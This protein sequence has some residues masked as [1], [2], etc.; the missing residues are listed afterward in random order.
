ME[1]FGQRLKARAREL[2]LSD[3]E[4]A[5]RAGL[6][7]RRYGHY[8]TDHREP[9]LKTVVLISEVLATTPNYLLGVEDGKTPSGKTGEREQLRAQVVATCDVLD[10]KHLQ[11]AVK[12]VAVLVE[13]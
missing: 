12:L 4:V 9:D 5:R 6:G 1:G 11:M 2:N 7:G 3:A 10:L 13:R 8:V